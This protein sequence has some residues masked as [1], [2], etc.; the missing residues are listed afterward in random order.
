M[1]PKL[2]KEMLEQDLLTDLAKT[3]EEPGLRLSVIAAIMLKVFDEYEIDALI[4]E[5]ELN[6]IQKNLPT[7]RKT[8]TPAQQ[9]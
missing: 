6:G 3:R 9:V 4:D 7:K 1:N 5:L 2:A 8:K